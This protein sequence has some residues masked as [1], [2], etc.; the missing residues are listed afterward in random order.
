MKNLAF[1]IWLLVWLPEKTCTGNMYLDEIKTYLNASTVAAKSKFTAADYHSY[2]L[3]K[4][5]SG[6]NKNESLAAFQSW[7]AP[8]HPDVSILNYAHG[9]S[10]WK[11]TFNEQN[12][13]S[14]AIN[15]PG[16]KGTT[17]FTFNADGLIK[18]TVYVPDSANPS[19]KPY[20]QPALTWLERNEP[21]EL[22]EVYQNNKLIQTEMSAN[23][24]KE[25][26][27]EW[28]SHADNAANHNK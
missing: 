10:I 21:L 6:K 18:E 19:Y 12:D 22:N 2:F 25:L 9:D 20:L 11:V 3:N 23:K 17:T 28:K 14:K 8:M 7:D 4:D 13:F 27:Q 26:L 5:Q 1:I 15:Y 16:W 24:W